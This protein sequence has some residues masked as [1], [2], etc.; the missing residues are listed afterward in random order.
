MLKII[1]VHIDFRLSISLLDSYIKTIT[2]VWCEKIISTYIFNWIKDIKNE[3]YISILQ[4]SKLVARNEFE[5]SSEN[6][7]VLPFPMLTHTHKLMIV[8]HIHTSLNFFVIWM[9]SNSVD[10]EH[11]AICYFHFIVHQLDWKFRRLK[12]WL[13]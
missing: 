2:K 3:S 5:D 6:K 13:K 7:I 9:V 10:R 4:M 11:S 12:M 8:R 1:T